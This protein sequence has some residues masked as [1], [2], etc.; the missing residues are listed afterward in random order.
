[1][2]RSVLGLLA[3]LMVLGSCSE[4]KEQVA[5]APIR[6]KTEVLTTA[7][8]GGGQTYVGIVEENEGTSV[9]FTGMGVV[10]R[11][12]VDEGQTVSRG[13]L[14]A[15]MDDTQARNLLSAAEAQM[16]Q[17]NDALERYGMLHDNGS[18]PEVQWVEI[19]SKVAQAK[20][21]LEIARKNLADCQLKAPVSGVVGRKLV[22]AGETALPSQ[23][24]ITILDVRSVKVKVSIPEAEMNAISPR[25]PSLIR[26][27]AIEQSFSGGLIEKGVTADALTHTYDVRINVPNAD[28][29]LLPGMV[30]SV[31]FAAA[32]PQLIGQEL[33][34]PV[35]SVQRKSDGSLF[36]WTVAAD[37]TAH[38]T[39]VGVGLT[40]GNRVV[41]TEGVT[42]QQRVVTEGYQKLSEGTRVVY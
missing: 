1:M 8:S 33:T 4:K 18:L 39:T 41:I 6:V 29:R 20:S 19:Q 42:P 25:T 36:V 2:N 13:Q 26:V 40:Q 27:E 28:R 35:T 10:R 37:S 15:V 31:R 38:R 23:A 32:E 21:Q 22:G 16:A 30:A 7:T 24:V 3:I 34:L 17:A 9:S 5:K 11:V 14:L 12:L